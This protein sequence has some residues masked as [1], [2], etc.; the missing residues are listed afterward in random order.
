MNDKQRMAENLREEDTDRSIQGL[1][2]KPEL[3]ITDYQR[4]N[5]NLPTPSTSLY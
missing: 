1:E 3:P 5:S 2:K 4:P